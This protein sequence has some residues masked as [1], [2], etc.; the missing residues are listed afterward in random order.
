MWHCDE[1]LFENL[2]VRVPAFC[3][4]YSVKK[5]KK[6]VKKVQYIIK[7]SHVLFPLEKTENAC[8]NIWAGTQYLLAF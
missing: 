7:N 6:K 1:C 5:K 2:V 3:T 4:G 8:C